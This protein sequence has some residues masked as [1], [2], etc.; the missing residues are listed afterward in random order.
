[1]NLKLYWA[2]RIVAKEEAKKNN[3]KEEYKKQEIL[4]KA[5]KEELQGFAKQYVEE[6]REEFKTLTQPKFVVDEKVLTNWYGEGDSW[7]GTT[8]ML[9]SHTPYRGPIAVKIKTVVLESLNLETK[10]NDLIEY[11]IISQC[12]ITYEGFKKFVNE[13]SKS[14]SE[15]PTISWAYN[16]KVVGDDN[17]YWQYTWRE[18]KLLKLDSSEAKYSIKAWKNEVE[19]EK[20]N[21]KKNALTIKLAKQIEKVNHIKVINVG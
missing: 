15:Y 4:R 16:I 11:D 20:L 21:K 3:Q 9:Q 13:R 12:M 2:K 19:I 18:A 14:W 1:M 5:R 8:C 6:K 10:L 7:E 17:I